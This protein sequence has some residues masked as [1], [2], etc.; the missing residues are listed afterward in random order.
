MKNISKPN[1]VISHNEFVEIINESELLSLEPSIL[2]MESEN[3]VGLAGISVPGDN[4]FYK[5]KGKWIKIL[6]F[7]HV[8]GVINIHQSLKNDNVTSIVKEVAE[9]LKGEI[10]E[11]KDS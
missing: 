10:N 1:V 11:T 3:G 5:F 9:K 4:A 8:E 2:N 7:D 6:E